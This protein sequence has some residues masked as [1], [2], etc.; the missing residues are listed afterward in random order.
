VPLRSLARTF[1]HR[2]WFAR[3]G[4]VLM[5]AD[6]LLGRLTRG[7]VVALGLIP[8]LLL[9]TTGRRSG[10][11]RTAPLLGVPDRDAV[12]VV[13]SNWGGP[14]HP[15]WALNLLA[16]PA[17]T[18]CRRGAGLPV[19]ARLLAGP[20]RDRA[21]QLA[22]RQWP[23]YQVYAERAGR[24]IHVFRLERSAPDG[25]RPAVPDPLWKE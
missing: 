5:P 9:T 19:R 17:A 13:G 1:G 3:L 23:A 14:R 20:E 24:P 2:R 22:L 12:I 25:T 8:A 18:V 15:A 21:W 7:R 16:D 4:R 10:R 11:P 6:R